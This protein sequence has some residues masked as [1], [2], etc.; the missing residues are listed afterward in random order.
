MRLADRTQSAGLSLG[1]VRCCGGRRGRRALI[2]AQSGSGKSL[3]MSS[4]TVAV[5]ILS[6]LAS[7]VF[8][9]LVD[10]LGGLLGVL[11][12]ATGPEVGAAGA[13]D[14]PLHLLAMAVILLL[15]DIASRLGAAGR[16]FEDAL[17]A[18]PHVGSWAMLLLGR[19]HADEVVLTGG[20][21]WVDLLAPFLG[22][23]NRCPG[24]IGFDVS[25]ATPET[26]SLVRSYLSSLRVE[27]PGIVSSRR[28]ELDKVNSNSS[29]RD[30]NACKSA[31]PKCANGAQISNKQDA[32][33]VR[34]TAS[35]NQPRR[36][37]C[38]N[39]FNT[40]PHG[41]LLR[42]PA[43]GGL[44]WRI[45]VNRCRDRSALCAWRRPQSK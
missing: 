32:S 37:K 16:A 38:A 22:L 31:G 41:G 1:I 43:A 19:H 35:I 7:G 12:H 26:V 21:A 8:V 3:I 6:N 23:T 20:L 25:R 27:I 40:R 17:A 34:L 2:R 11:A 15:R 4:L 28:A 24:A 13:P 36:G 29:Y 9:G 44:G 45:D 39:A 18:L 30:R 5:V 14:D 33:R 42:L 10:H